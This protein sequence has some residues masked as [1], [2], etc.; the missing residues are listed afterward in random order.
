MTTLW[1]R[2]GWKIVKLLLFDRFI[3]PIPVES[4]DTSLPTFWRLACLQLKLVNEHFKINVL[5]PFLTSLSLDVHSKACSMFKFSAMDHYR[6]CSIFHIHIQPSHCAWSS[7]MSSQNL[8]KQNTGAA[9][10]NESSVVMPCM[11]MARGGEDSGEKGTCRWCMCTKKSHTPFFLQLSGY[12][13]YLLHSWLYHHHLNAAKLWKTPSCTD[14]Y[15]DK[16]DEL[17]VW[18]ISTICQ[19]SHHVQKQALQHS[20]STLDWALCMLIWHAKHALAGTEFLHPSLRAACTAGRNRPEN[21]FTTSLWW[22]QAQQQD[23]QKCEPLPGSWLLQMVIH[24]PWMTWWQDAI[25]KGLKAVVPKPIWVMMPLA[26][27]SSWMTLAHPTWILWHRQYHE[28]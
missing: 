19:W 25:L 15:Q 2:L 26:A 12:W 10:G 20:H 17:N 8:T 16:C 4:E 1:D 7:Y 9:G 22:W 13:K 6:S 11:C 23:W 21:P 14:T 18:I 3:Y 28:T 24:V 5:F 27:S